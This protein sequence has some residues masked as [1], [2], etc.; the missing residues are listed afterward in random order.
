M[1]AKGVEKRRKAF[2][3]RRRVL[4]RW[5]AKG[6]AG[7]CLNRKWRA[8][9]DLYESSELSYPI[10]LSFRLAQTMLPFVTPSH[11]R[12]CWRR[13]SVISF[14]RPFREMPEGST[15]PIELEWGSEWKIER[16]RGRS[17]LFGEGYLQWR[18]PSE[19]WT[20]WITRV[21]EEIKRRSRS[22]SEREINLQDKTTCSLHP[23][24][25]LALW[26][27]ATL[28]FKRFV[29]LYQFQ[30]QDTTATPREDVPVDVVRANW[31]VGP[32]RRNEMKRTSWAKAEPA[33]LA[34]V[35][36][37]MWDNF[38]DPHRTHD[39]VISVDPVSFFSPLLWPI[40]IH[41]S[42]AHT[43][44]SCL[45]DSPSSSSSSSSSPKSPTDNTLVAS[46][47][48]RLATPTTMDTS[49]STVDADRTDSTVYCQCGSSSG[50]NGCVL[51]VLRDEEK[52]CG[53]ESC[54]PL[55]LTVVRHVLDWMACYACD[56]LSSGRCRHVLEA[57][58][59][60]ELMRHY[61]YPF[62]DEM[63]RVEERET[64]LM[65]EIILYSPLTGAAV[66]FYV[67]TNEPVQHLAHLTWKLTL[68]LSAEEKRQFEKSRDTVPTVTSTC[69]ASWVSQYA[70]YRKLY[71]TREREKL[72]LEQKENRQVNEEGKERKEEEKET[73]K[74]GGDKKSIGGGC[75]E[76]DSLASLSTVDRIKWYK[77][78]TTKLQRL[79][80]EERVYGA[81]QSV[82]DVLSEESD[83][84][85]KAQ[86]GRGKKRPAAKVW[87]ERGCRVELSFE[88]EGEEEDIL[89]EFS[90]D[91]FPD[92][93]LP[94]GTHVERVLYRLVRA[95]PPA[96]NF[97]H[98]WVDH[99]SS[100]SSPSHTVNRDSVI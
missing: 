6:I 49:P 2:E 52:V 48:L 7:R 14:P 19:Q 70:A 58:L 87:M 85:T 91:L 66:F 96:W 45:S 88:E 40:P 53:E 9:Y 81:V 94:L 41:S 69:P 73:E 82:C 90:I 89:I 59:S 15:L 67:K 1:V 72:E 74:K 33:F 65:E 17:L 26:D 3:R 30:G 42:E 84:F 36:G 64:R 8:M 29:A 97:L 25:L 32:F 61:Y 78:H 38:E 100:S 5:S 55:L 37:V 39:E 86:S 75:I 71:A 12:V 76:S 50:W 13:K 16:C 34:L 68:L 60:P 31:N 92:T 54:A 51:S 93:T 27:G 80:E 46:R 4:E 20:P 47:R 99:L 11:T 79:L 56:N 63:K 43:F 95:F 28:H 24:R 21:K 83:A 77:N 18:L 62:E 23:S 35:P 98:P 57:P 44:L 10:E 22:L